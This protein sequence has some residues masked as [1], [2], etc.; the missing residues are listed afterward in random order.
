MPNGAFPQPYP[1]YNNTIHLQRFRGQFHL[2]RPGDAA[3]PLFAW[4]AEMDLGSDAPA[5]LVVDAREFDWQ[6]AVLQPLAERLI[7][8][9]KRTIFTLV[10]YGCT[11]FR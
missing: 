2:R 6:P 5:R 4:Q 9:G 1:Q 3:P 11:K 8:T 10:P 7:S